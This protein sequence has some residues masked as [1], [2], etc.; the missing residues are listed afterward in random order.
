MSYPSN[1]LDEGYARLLLQACLSHGSLSA[2][3]GSGGW[4][5]YAVR[6]YLKLTRNLEEMLFG[7]FYTSCGQC[8]RLRELPSLECENNP[9]GSRGIYVWNGS[10]IYLIRHHKAKRSTN[11]EFNVVRFLPARLGVVTVRYLSY[12]RRV[13]S[14]L[15][16]ELDEHMRTLQPATDTPF[17]FQNQER[18]WSTQRMT[19][20]LK[21]ATC[22]VWPSAVTCQLYRQ[23]TVGITKEA[24]SR[25]IHTIQPIRQ[26]WTYR[27]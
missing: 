2:L 24:C 18:Q 3:S 22:Q 4:S 10:V 14:I 5:W 17:L 7:G 16:R 9:I 13:A 25:G 20:I 26:P 8:P 15:R 1:G 6:Q 27:R 12:I 23:V 19:S 21:A 11:H